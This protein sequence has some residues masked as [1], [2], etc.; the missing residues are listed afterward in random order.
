MPPL[1]R[2]EVPR[3]DGRPRIEDRENLGPVAAPCR[4]MGAS[5]SHERVI[6][7]REPSAL[8]QPEMLAQSRQHADCGAG[9][10]AISRIGPELGHGDRPRFLAAHR[11]RLSR[12]GERIQ[13]GLMDGAAQCVRPQAVLDGPPVHLTVSGFPLAPPALFALFRRCS[14][15]GGV[16][17]QPLR[18]APRFSYSFRTLRAACS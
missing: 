11:V 7:S 5:Q 17:E 10:R 13:W 4:S 2:P 16:V 8:G 15:G 3:R 12:L 18:F 1:T 14:Q 6:I 9:K